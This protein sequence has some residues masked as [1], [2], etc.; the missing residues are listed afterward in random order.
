MSK[1]IQKS[2][3]TKNIIDEWLAKNG[4]PKIEKQVEKEIE[5]YLKNKIA[6]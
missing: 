1:R 5:E 4:D 6:P 2:P 3:E